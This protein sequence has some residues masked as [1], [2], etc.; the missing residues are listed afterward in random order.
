MGTLRQKAYFAWRPR[1]CAM[2]S[3]THGRMMGTDPGMNDY[4][5]AGAIVFGKKKVTLPDGERR[6]LVRPAAQ[7]RIM[8]MVVWLCMVLT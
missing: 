1:R 3:P 5:Y 4:E 2:Y 8:G 6:T 7:M